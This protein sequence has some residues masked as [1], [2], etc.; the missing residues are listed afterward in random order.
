MSV[1]EGSMPALW[2]TRSC[3]AKHRKYP[4]VWPNSATAGDTSGQETLQRDVALT[5]ATVITM[6]NA[7]VLIPSDCNGGK[8]GFEK[9]VPATTR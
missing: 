3:G 9:D 4:D 2:V 6:E 8:N 1:V 5:Q 7:S